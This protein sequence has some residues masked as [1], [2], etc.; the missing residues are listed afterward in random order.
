MWATWM[1]CGLSSLMYPK[2]WQHRLAPHV[3]LGENKLSRGPGSGRGD[4]LLGPAPRGPERETSLHHGGW[5]GRSTEPSSR[6]HRPCGPPSRVCADL[7]CPAVDSGRG[8]PGPGS[9]CQGEQWGW[10]GDGGGTRGGRRYEVGRARRPVAAGQGGCGQEACPVSAADGAPFPSPLQGLLYAHTSRGVW[11][12]QCPW[13]APH[14]T[15]CSCH[16]QLGVREGEAASG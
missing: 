16:G 1:G 12:G 14:H 4:G 10:S 13:Q 6:E 7:A 2:C 11:G 15:L 8:S 3:F 9:D 5:G